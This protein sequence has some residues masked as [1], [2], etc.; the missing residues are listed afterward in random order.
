MS[1]RQALHEADQDYFAIHVPRKAPRLRDV[2]ATTA[3]GA[4]VDPETV[5]IQKNADGSVVIAKKDGGALGRF[6]L[7]GRSHACV[8][9]VARGM[10]RKEAD[11]TPNNIIVVEPFG[12]GGIR[13]PELQQNGNELTV[14]DLSGQQFDADAVAMNGDPIDVGVLLFSKFAIAAF[15]ERKAAA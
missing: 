10:S 15:R 6:M 1:V 3:T 8:R 7:T 5:D 2:L 13:G 11:L 12:E 9:I 14:F 4:R